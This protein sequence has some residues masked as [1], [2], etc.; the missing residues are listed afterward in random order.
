MTRWGCGKDEEQLLQEVQDQVI[1]DETEV[2]G[3]SGLQVQVFI[4]QDEVGGVDGKVA[5]EQLVREVL[6]VE[7]VVL[8]LLLGLEELQVLI[9]DEEEVVAV[10][11]MVQVVSVVPVSLSFVTHRLNLFLSVLQLLQLVQ[12]VIILNKLILELRMGHIGL[13][14][15]VWRHFR[16]IVI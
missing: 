1:M 16:R 9:L 10:K 15:V 8:P 5:E 11:V 12:V 7:E 13:P 6:E 4:M 14:Q 3:H 2:R